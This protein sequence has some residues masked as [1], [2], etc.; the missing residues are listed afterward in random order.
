M[1]ISKTTK[2]AIKSCDDVEVK[3]GDCLEVC[4]DQD[5]CDELGII[6]S[7]KAQACAIVKDAI[8]KLAEVAEIDEQAREAI[9]NLSVVLLDL[10]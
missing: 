6:D 5:L 3:A 2:S 10:K 1:K 8:D 7:P 4:D 9:A